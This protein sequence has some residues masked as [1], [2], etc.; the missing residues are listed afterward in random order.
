MIERLRAA[1][2]RHTASYPA[3]PAAILAMAVGLLLVFTIPLT[4]TPPSLALV[5]ALYIAVGVAAVVWSRLGRSVDIQNVVHIAMTLV[6][7]FG[8]LIPAAIP[9]PLVLIV[10]LLIPALVVATQGAQMALWHSLA[11][12]TAT[13][14]GQGIND[15]L[16]TNL[17]ALL[18]GQVAILL[19]LPTPSSEQT[20]VVPEA[21][22]TFSR[23][24]SVRLVVPPQFKIAAEDLS[25]TSRSIA[26]ASSQQ[27]MGANE[28]STVIIDADKQIEHFLQITERANERARSIT[29]LAQQ[30]LD[31]FQGGQDS[32]GKVTTGMAQIREQ[33]AA[34][35]NTIASLVQLTQK[36]DDIITSVSE[37]ATQSNLLALN[38]SIEA[39]RAG[40]HGRGFAVVAEEVR[41]L[42]SQSTAAARQVRE[43]LVQIQKAMRDT[44][45]ATEVGIGSVDAGVN[46]TE[47]IESVMVQ[48]AAN[49]TK[50]HGAVREFYDTLRQQGEGL[51]GIGIA[52]ERIE[53]MAQQQLTHA[54]SIE[55]AASSL[56]ALASNLQL[57]LATASAEAAP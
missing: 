5:G 15:S 48:M 56:S 7:A 42:S 37:I 9:S 3:D 25:R 34:I 57:V 20:G 35:A 11:I 54:H 40:V 1:I 36:V 32:I 21:N 41:T 53:R 45:S 16:F 17:G 46:M 52:L 2:A 22:P 47:E 29:Q 4:L 30:A 24:P 23:R 51:E 43:I 26:D 55:T 27:I 49:V 6:T 18:I 28:Q 38:A 14:L 12:L 13:L 39:A 10:A 44:V 31:I 50:S 33:V 8:L 19:L